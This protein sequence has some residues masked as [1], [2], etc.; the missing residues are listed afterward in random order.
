V[1]FQV[2]SAGW[3][4]VVFNGALS[5]R[6]TEQSFARVLLRP[7]T[8]A[9]G[10]FVE[11]W[12]QSG[13]EFNGKLRVETAAADAKPLLSYES[14]TLG[15][16]VRLTNKFSSN[17]MA[18]HL[19]LT[20][21]KERFGDPATLEKGADTIAEWGRERGLDLQGIDIDNG[22]GLSRSTHISVLQL[23]KTLSAA[24]RSRFAPEFMASL[25]LAGLD[26][27][28]RSRM[29]SS[30]GGSVRLKTGHLDGVSGVAGYVT[31]AGGKTYVLASLVNN[32]RADY[33]AAEPLHAA[34][35]AWMLNDL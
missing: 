7:T 22:S 25:P 5:A 23:A 9:Y 17:L 10:T 27:T 33:G 12:R 26:G 32:A 29:K 30:P 20:V 34:L 2:A 35:V 1:E 8:Y 21:G 3:D 11:L 16:I 6:C 15:E 14:L 13:G 4:R 19:L 31:T 28:L 18:R 24:F